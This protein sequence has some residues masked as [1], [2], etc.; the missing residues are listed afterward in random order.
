MTESERIDFLITALESGNKS[1]FAK[2]I[3]CSLPNISKICKGT[4]GIRLQISK[5]C[6]AYPRVNREWL[7]TGEGYPGD[8]TIDL[9]KAR[10]EKK[11]QQN[12]RIID[13]LISRIEELERKEVGAV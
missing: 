5:I 3:G 10:Y 9:V 6:E 7:E 2:K 13:S 12:E 1:L 8:L 11:I 4:T